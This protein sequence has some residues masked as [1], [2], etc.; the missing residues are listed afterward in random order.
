MTRIIK[1]ASVL[2][3][4]C[5]LLSFQTILSFAIDNDEESF[6]VHFSHG[7][8]VESSPEFYEIDTNEVL[9]VLHK[10]LTNNLR[11]EETLPSSVDLTDTNSQYNQYFPAIG[12][13]Y[14]TGACGSFA[15][16]YYQF[17]Y[18]AN[19]YSDIVTTPS[20]TYCP[21][22][23]YSITQI[24]YDFGSTFEASYNV[25]ENLGC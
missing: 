10:N 22:F 4:L 24:G 1:I 9:G 6:V 3:S 2:L 8:L 13:Q 21:Q 23:V 18:E 20:N 19:K 11:D 16:A 15:T 14:S 25:L 5:C 7:G 12:H 17:T